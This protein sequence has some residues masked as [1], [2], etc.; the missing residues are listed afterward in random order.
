MCL[1]GQVAGTA[2]PLP[3]PRCF[4]VR[5]FT[6]RSHFPEPKFLTSLRFIPLVLYKSAQHLNKHMHFAPFSTLDIY[7]AHILPNDLKRPW[8]VSPSPE[9]LPQ[10]QHAME[11]FWTGFRSISWLMFSV[12]CV[13]VRGDAREVQGRLLVLN[14]LMF[15]LGNQD[16]CAWT[17]THEQAHSTHY[18]QAH[19][20]IC[21]V[22]RKERKPRRTWRR[23]WG[24]KKTS[25]SPSWVY[26][27]WFCPL[28]SH[29]AIFSFL[30]MYLTNLMTL[31]MFLN[32]LKSQFL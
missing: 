13:G 31:G 14:K 21:T 19:T 15:W 32:F 8:D 11:V 1:P 27:S 18:K 7:L 10:A 24:R 29:S 4:A 2:L 22:D 3:P 25:G 16:A 9:H 30:P 12:L 23:A 6:W 17:I 28:L 26:P 5:L 20:T